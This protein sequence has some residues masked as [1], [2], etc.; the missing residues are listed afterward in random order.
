MY[1]SESNKLHT[2]WVPC[3]PCTYKT[4]FED[5]KYVNHRTQL[6]FFNKGIFC[7]CHKGQCGEC[8]TA[9]WQSLINMIH[10][11]TST[12]HTQTHSCIHV[13]TH[14][15][16]SNML[17]SLLLFYHCCYFSYMETNG[18]RCKRWG[19]V[20]ERNRSYQFLRWADIS[21]TVLI[22]ILQSLEA[23]AVWPQNMMSQIRQNSGRRPAPW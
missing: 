14:S 23:S 6:T 2:M 12:N 11:L 9:A 20:V 1:T 15:V 3:L 7:I 10:T 18:T 13:S 21:F 22:K 19:I 5:N 8:T 4:L 17:V 16:R